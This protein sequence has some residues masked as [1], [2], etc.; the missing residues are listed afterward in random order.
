M[1]FSDIIKSYKRDKLK[2]NDKE[3]VLRRNIAQQSKDLETFRQ[4]QAAAKMERYKQEV[5]QSNKLAKTEHI[6]AAKADVG[7]RLRNFGS[8]VANHLAK[9]K[10]V[11]AQ[12]AAKQANRFG[13]NVARL[14]QNRGLDFTNRGIGDMGTGYSPFNPRPVIAKP[15]EKAVIIKIMR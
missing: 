10:A 6:R 14:N 4:E 3:L 7:Q 13:S 5:A 1:N 8:N 11:N 2:Q 15:K 9:R 12:K